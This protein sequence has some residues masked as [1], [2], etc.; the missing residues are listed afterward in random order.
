MQF[1]I[2]K[3]CANK[4]IKLADIDTKDKTGLPEGK[5]AREEWLRKHSPEL[6]ELQNQFYAQGKHKILMILQ[7]MD[8]SGKD[9]TVR[10]VFH[11]VDPL[12]I[13]VRAFK[14]P[15]ER[16]LA[17]DFLWRIHQRVPKTGEIVIFNRSHYEDVLV[18]HVKNWID[19][20]EYE[21]RI[22]HINDFERMLTET[23]TII[24]KIF[25]HISKDEQ[26]ERLQKRLDNP[27]KHWKFNPSDLEDRQ[28]WDKFQQQYE[29]VIRA[30]SSKNAPWHIV[31]ADSKSARNV[32]VM[33]ILLHYLRSL[34]LGYPTIDTRNWPKLVD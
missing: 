27:K 8:T 16:E 19:D 28:L 17:H 18:T 1:Q 9:G 12:G 22:R 24:I 15:N 30:T 26:K 7:G 2:K 14:A 10:W 6:D 25:L 13:F 31:P 4:D 29:N 5:K 32:V 20:A 33:N 21:R 34:K 3:Y 11:D 23:G